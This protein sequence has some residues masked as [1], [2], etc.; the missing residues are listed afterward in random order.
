MIG[1]DIKLIGFNI[2]IG[3]GMIEELFKEGLGISYFFYY[4]EKRIVK[5]FICIEYIE[6]NIKIILI[7]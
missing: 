3:L 6:C 5:E 1:L 2:V 7:F 4:I